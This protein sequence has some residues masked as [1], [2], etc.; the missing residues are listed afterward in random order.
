MERERK[1]IVSAAVERASGL[2]FPYS[3][4]L[5]EEEGNALYAAL[6]TDLDDP[7]SQHRPR[8]RTALTA[9]DDPVDS[10]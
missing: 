4:P 10:V 9:D 6:T 2:V 1:L 8:V 5:L 7:I 3:A